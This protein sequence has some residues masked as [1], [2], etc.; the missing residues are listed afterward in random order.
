VKQRMPSLSSSTVR[1]VVS[2]KSAASGS[3]T[4][5]SSREFYSAGRWRITEI[6]AGTI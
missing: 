5:W 4:A 6:R 1:L 3:S 2:R